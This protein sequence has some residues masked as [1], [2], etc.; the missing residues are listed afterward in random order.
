MRLAETDINGC[1]YLNLTTKSD[2]RGKFVK[3]FIKKLLFNL[4][5]KLDVHEEYY[6]ISH[7]NVLRG[8]HF[9]IPPY[10]NT[11]LIICVKGKIQDVILDLRK[12]S[13]TFGQYISFILD[14]NEPQLLVIPNGCAHGFY[15]F[16]ND[17]IVLYKVT[18]SYQPDYDHGIRWNSFGAV[19]PSLKPILSERD[20]NL[21]SLEH[22][23]S[24]FI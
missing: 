18:S 13:P 10:E 3:Y 15:S 17:T 1:Y 23:D 14:S 5:T 6:S 16:E 11:K 20:K 22:F 19:W 4:N 2:T 24:P 8:M 9:Q 21:P 12:S 7:K